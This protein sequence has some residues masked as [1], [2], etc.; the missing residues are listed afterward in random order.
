MKETA[1]ASIFWSLS[2]VTSSARRAVSSGAIVEP[3]AARRSCHFEA[4]L[5]L[6]Q[7][8]L[9]M[10]VQVECER[11]IAAPQFQ[12][13]A[14]T[15]GRDPRGARAIALDVG[16]DHQRG[17]ELHH[18]GLAEIDLGLRHGVHD[19]A[20]EIAMS[21]QALRVGQIAVGRIVGHEIG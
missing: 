9:A 6:H 19:A 8:R 11:A 16:V 10:I 20:D 18:L 15:F 7:N 4:K 3:S 17:A 13:I 5:A 2:S 14:E 12:R 21:R 1:T